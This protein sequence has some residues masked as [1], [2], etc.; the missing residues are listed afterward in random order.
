MTEE[1]EYFASDFGFMDG[2]GYM[3]DGLWKCTFRT[4]TE[5]THGATIDTE[6]EYIFAHTYESLMRTVVSM[7]EWHKE[8][9]ANDSKLQSVE[10]VTNTIILDREWALSLGIIKDDE[11]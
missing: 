11:Q 2:H 7:T 4:Y 10:L 6:T 5:S 9:G 8:I 3:A 1:H